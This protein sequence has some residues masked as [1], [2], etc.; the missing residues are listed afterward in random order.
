MT[1]ETAVIDLTT[2]VTNA[3]GLMTTQ[4]ASVASAIAAAVLVSTNNSQIP[5]VIIATN[6]IKT[7]T[8]LVPKL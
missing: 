2:Q 8:L 3:V 7:Q 6:M 5:L 1:T 4:N